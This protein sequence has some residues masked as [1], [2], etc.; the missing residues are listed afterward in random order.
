MIKI[1]LIV[2]KMK[3]YEMEERENL[4]K[5]YFVFISCVILGMWFNFLYFSFVLENNDKNN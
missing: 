1:K 3:V 5:F 4:L 2:K